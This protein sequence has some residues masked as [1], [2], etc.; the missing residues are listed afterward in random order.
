[1]SKSQVVK[2][3]DTNMAAQDVKDQ[4]LGRFVSRPVENQLTRIVDHWQVSQPPHLRHLA[5]IRDTAMG[6]K[7]TYYVHYTYDNFKKLVE[8]GEASWE[9]VSI[10]GAD[11]K[12]MQ[13]PAFAADSN[14]EVDEFGFPNIPTVL[15]QGR[16]NDATVSQCAN[17]VDVHMAPTSK[18]D[19]VVRALSDGIYGT[20]QFRHLQNHAD[21]TRGPTRPGLARK[22][23]TKTCGTKSVDA[24][25]VHKTFERPTSSRSPAE[26]H[27]ERFADGDDT[28]PKGKVYEVAAS[29]SEISKAQG[30]KRGCETTR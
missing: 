2:A 19:P 6:K 14:V 12:D 20:S 30:R 23:V 15:F 5:I 11:S 7:S 9:A 29:S 17:A 4:V 3:T 26:S 27:W 21:C 25:I 24:R 8:N 13:Q 18:N 28:C 16:H 1:M 10:V 22:K